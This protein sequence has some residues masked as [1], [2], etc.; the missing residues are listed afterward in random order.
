MVSIERREQ[1]SW[2]TPKAPLVL[3]GITAAFWIVTN[4]WIAEDRRLFEFPHEWA[5]LF[6]V[7]ILIG[8][9]AFWAIECVKWSRACLWIGAIGFVI[10]AVLWWLLW[11]EDFGA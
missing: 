1:S 11:T 3:L 2:D 4:N 7:M 8:S 6:T 10:S 5:L 9:I